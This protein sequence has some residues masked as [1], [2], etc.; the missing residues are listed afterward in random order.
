MKRLAK[1]RGDSMSFDRRNF[2][3]ESVVLGGAF[4][5][6]PMHGCQISGESG[7]WSREPS[8]PDSH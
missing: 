1:M 6:T 5:R 8:L 7:L 3:R 4:T 2:I